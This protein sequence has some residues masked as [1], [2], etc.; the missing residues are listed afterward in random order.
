MR[1]SRTA[2]NGSAAPACPIVMAMLDT[3]LFTAMRARLDRKKALA[4]DTFAADVPSALRASLGFMLPPRFLATKQV[5]LR[6][7]I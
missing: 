3:S 7:S 6:S 5:R 2:C 4:G 1:F